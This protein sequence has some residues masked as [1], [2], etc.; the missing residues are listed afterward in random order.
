ML[1]RINES[2]KLTK[3]NKQEIAWVFPSILHCRE[4]YN[5]T[6]RIRNYYIGIK[7]YT[8]FFV[9]VFSRFRVSFQ[10]GFARYLLAILST[11]A[12]SPNFYDLRLFRVPAQLVQICMI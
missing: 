5:K 4:K 12:T 7:L 8:F 3:P 10:R 1:Y 11:C 6:Y 2:K 9:A